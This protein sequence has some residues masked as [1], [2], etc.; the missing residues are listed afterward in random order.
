MSKYQKFVPE[1]TRLRSTASATAGKFQSGSAFHISAQNTSVDQKFKELK[2]QQEMFTVGTW[3]ME[4]AST[5]YGMETQ[6]VKSHYE[7]IHMK[8]PWPGRN[9]LV[10]SL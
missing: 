2:L 8:C 1:R 9:I 10:G 6:G 3:N 4:C 5:A 7:E